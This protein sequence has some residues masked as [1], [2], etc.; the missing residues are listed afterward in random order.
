MEPIS[1]A[2][3]AAVTAGLTDVGK[4]AVVDAYKGLKALITRKFGAQNKVIEAVTALEASPNSKGRQLTVYEELAAIQ[5]GQDAE[6]MRA[7][8]SLL[9]LLKAEP[10]GVQHVHQVATQIGD[11]NANVNIAGSGN[12]VGPLDRRS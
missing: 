6:L 2:I 8:E 1:T 3:I 7:A 5:G 10:G 12:Q 4:S 9:D 11:Y